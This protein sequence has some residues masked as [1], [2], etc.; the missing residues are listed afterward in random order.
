MI[1]A[2]ISVT[3]VPEMVTLTDP[4]AVLFGQTRQDVLSLLFTRPDEAFYL[5]EIVRRTGRGIG[6]VQRDLGQLISCGIVRKEKER[7]YRANPDSPVYEPLKQIVIRTMGL[8][9][10][11]QNALSDLKPHIAVAFIFGSFARGEPRER[12]D[13][14]LMIVTQDDQL[15]LEQVVTQLHEQQMVLQREINP[16]VLAASELNAK[17]LAKNH[18]IRRVLAGDK[19][20]LIGDEDELERMA[21]KRVAQKPSD[22]P[23]GNRRSARGRGSRSKGLPDKRA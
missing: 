19:T 10:V 7:F 6:P 17:W 15:T 2:T 5:R 16:F 3:I 12:S 11:L 8:A 13:I 1:D 20:F 9:N 22:Q 14:D 4:A 23:A 21:E 18:F